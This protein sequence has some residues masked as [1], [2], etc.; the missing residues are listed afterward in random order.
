MANEP[1]FFDLCQ[2]SVDDDYQSARSAFVAATDAESMESA[3]P[4]YISALKA[5]V[6]SCDAY[7]KFY[8]K[9]MEA[10]EFLDTYGASYTGEAMDQLAEYLE[11]DDIEPGEQF[12]NGSAAYFLNNG[13]L[14]AT[15]ILAEIEYMTQL[16]NNAQA[17]SMKDGDDVT[18]MLKNPHFAE[19]DGWSKV[20]LPEWPMGPDDYKLG[21]AYSILFDVYQELDGLQNGLYELT[22]NDFYRP[23]NYGTAEYET[24]RA[25]VYLNSDEAKMNTIESG[26]TTELA[27]GSDYQLSDGTY[28]PNDVDGAAQAFKDGR[29]QQKVYGIVYD[30]KLKIGLRTDVRFEGNWGVWSDFR[31]TFRAKNVEVTKEV[32][33]STIPNAEELLNNK[34]GNTELNALSEALSAAQTAA[35]ADA[36]DALVALKSAIEDVKACTDT[37]T[38]LQQAINN[39]KTAIDDNPSYSKID[40]ANTLYSE[41]L[42]AYESGTYDNAAATAK[43]EELAEMTVAVKL[44]DAGDEPQDVTNLLINPT[45]DKDHGS[46]EEGWIEG[47]ITTAMN[48]YKQGTVS[49]NRAPFELY[50]DLKG[51]PKGKYIVKVHTYYR[52]GYYD[53][54]AQRIANGEETKLTT[55][56][57]ESSA[58]KA[59]MKVKNLIDDADTETFDV[60]CYTYDDG[61]HAP[62]GTTPTVAWFNQGKYLNELEFTVGE[63]GK[64]RI[65]LSK[66][67]TYANDYEVVGAWELYY[68]GDNDR[69]ELIVNPDF[70]KDRGSKEDG[71]IEGWVTT[72]MNGYKQGTVSYNRAPF[73]LYQDLNGLPAGIYEVTVQTYYRAGYY[74]EEVQHIANGEDTKLTTLYA[75]TSAKK[76]ETKVM[77]LID[78]ADSETFDVNCYTYDDGRHAP[79]GTTPTVAWFK[80]GKYLNRLQFEV[81]ADGKVRIGLIKDETY[82]ND[83][84]VVGSWRLYYLG[85]A[86]GLKGDVNGDNM[87]DISDV[88]AIINQMAGIADYANADVNGDNMVDISDVV[89]VINIMAGQQ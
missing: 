5:K 33:A 35:D 64:A 28:V 23:A 73:H 59:E 1:D 20:G 81:P 57:A 67:E 71:W 27:Y 14:D 37:Y 10:E 41:A 61:R 39:L 86:E 58:G 47:W 78:D 42:A 65:G 56:Y 9:Y 63:D 24:F 25:Y 82:A 4:V 46:K 48:G 18:G 49:Y 16:R 60:N 89:A 17:N 68:L 32:I 11:A 50:Q 62:D 36:Y 84:E 22:L 83:Y 74:D 75:E 72:A 52:A 30:G 43:A 8:A 29:Y 38:K 85:K 66:T 51:L 53:E 31:L 88:V 12:P 80:Q 40:D 69:T 54:E 34:C 44:G 21:Q 3:Y 79:D 87:V 7:S 55:L 70:D 6:E 15:T 19:L 76:E 2:K 13:T 26:A 45:F 77:N